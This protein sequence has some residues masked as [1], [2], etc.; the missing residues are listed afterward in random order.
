MIDRYLLRYFLAVVDG[1][2]FTAAAAQVN[3]T[4]PTLSAGIAKLER[5]VGAKLFRR[6]SQ[7]VELTGAGARF[8]GHARRIEREFQLAQSAVSGVEP[9]ATLRLG[10]LTTLAT[11]DLSGLVRRLAISAPTTKVELVEANERGLAQYL[12]RG[13]LDLAL[14]T[15]RGEHSDA[16]EPLRCEA[17]ALAMACDHALAHERA[18]PAEALVGETMIV[19]RHCEALPE[20][21]RH[22]TQRGIRPFFALRTTNDDRAMEMV[23]AKLGVTV[24]PASFAQPGIATPALIGFDLRR[25]LGVVWGE[26]AQ[27]LR[28][29]AAPLLKALSEQF[30][31]PD[32]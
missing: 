21:S 7:R 17:Y 19:R 28:A 31:P 2:T 29:S 4:Q 1:G 27:H 6:N 20:T 26:N 9:V 12:A 8:V 24:V 14:T 15:L 3:V 32:T 30:S 10:V 22:F 5:E 16:G 13:R 25:T 23:R 18:V 11:A